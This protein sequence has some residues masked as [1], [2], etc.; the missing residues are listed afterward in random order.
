MVTVILQRSPHTQQIDYCLAP[1]VFLDEYFG[2]EE[3][4]LP[5][6][7]IYNGTTDAP[8]L[9]GI[10]K[11]ELTTG[12]RCNCETTTRSAPLMTNVPFSVM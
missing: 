2:I 9:A 6:L 7:L 5:V 4:D 10:A 1:S 11:E 8:R 12:E 3:F